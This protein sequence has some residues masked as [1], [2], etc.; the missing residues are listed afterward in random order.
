MLELKKFTRVTS[1]SCKR[2]IFM[3]KCKRRQIKQKAI[4]IDTYLNIE[5]YQKRVKS[6]KNVSLKKHAK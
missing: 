4:S 5:L 1:R 2:N 3:Q 6:S